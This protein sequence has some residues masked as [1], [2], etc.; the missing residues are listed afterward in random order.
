MSWALRIGWG[1][2]VRVF[3]LSFWL[4]RVLLFLLLLLLSRDIFMFWLRECTSQSADIARAD[5]I[6]TGSLM[7]ETNSTSRRQL[8]SH[9]RFTSSFLPAWGEH[10]LQ[11]LPSTPIQLSTSK[12]LTSRFYTQNSVSS[13]FDLR[14]G[15]RQSLKIP[16]THF[17]RLTRTRTRISEF[18]R[19]QPSIQQEILWRKTINSKAQHPFSTAAL[20]LLEDFWKV[21]KLETCGYGSITADGSSDRA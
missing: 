16:A 9:Y 17:T 14:S 1:L 2:G 12:R 4:C 6:L 21:W 15:K 8:K 13:H 7:Q 19:H 20:G 10:P 11:Q 3:P 5:F 18:N